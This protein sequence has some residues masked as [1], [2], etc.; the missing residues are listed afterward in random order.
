[1]ERIISQD[2]YEIL[3]EIKK[4]MGVDKSLKEMYDKKVLRNNFPLLIFPVL[5]ST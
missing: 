5:A 2:D 4:L 3:C 1:M